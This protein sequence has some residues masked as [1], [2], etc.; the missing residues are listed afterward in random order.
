MKGALPCP[1]HGLRSWL[2]L[3]SDTHLCVVPF[4]QCPFSH[5]LDMFKAQPWTGGEANSP[6]LPATAS[7]A[8]SDGKPFRQITRKGQTHN[9]N[10]ISRGLLLQLLHYPFSFV[11]V[12]QGSHILHFTSRFSDSV[13]THMHRHTRTHARAESFPHM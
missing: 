2:A 4:P 10:H 8:H 1:Q 11:L 5:N 12:T 7:P 3:V 9:A 6:S 13:L